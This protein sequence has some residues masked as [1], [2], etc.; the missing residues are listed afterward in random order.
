MN[1][2]HF[3][4]TIH[5]KHTNTVW[6]WCRPIVDHIGRSLDWTK[7]VSVILMLSIV[8]CFHKP[9]SL[10]NRFWTGQGKGTSALANLVQISEAS[11]SRKF[12]LTI[13][14]MIISHATTKQHND[15]WFIR[16][17]LSFRHYITTENRLPYLE[18][19]F[20]DTNNN[21]FDTCNIRH[22]T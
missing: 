2:L 12:L 8:Y 4:P 11:L 7:L 15:W 6:Q 20:R 9:R 13:P 17:L 21:Y 16:S 22:R 1:F 3:S 14:N 19:R 10:L 18:I 5:Y